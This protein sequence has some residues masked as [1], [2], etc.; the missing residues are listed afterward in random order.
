MN[1]AVY[2]DLAIAV[3]DENNNEVKFNRDDIELSYKNEVGEQEVIVKYKGN[4]YFKSAVATVR[5]NIVESNPADSW[6]VVGIIGA[7]VVVLGIIGVVIYRK[8]HNAS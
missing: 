5:V 7:I 8:K 1:D 3:V 6:M 4:N 2:Q